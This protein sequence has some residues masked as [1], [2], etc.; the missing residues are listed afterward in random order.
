[1]EIQGNTRAIQGSTRNFKAAQG[2]SPRRL[3]CPICPGPWPSWHLKTET[4]SF[5][6]SF[7]ELLEDQI[8]HGSIKDALNSEVH[9]SISHAA[10]EGKEGEEAEGPEG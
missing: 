6:T 4:R 9:K 8:I 3:P 2:H 7:P 1:M 10:E 5:T